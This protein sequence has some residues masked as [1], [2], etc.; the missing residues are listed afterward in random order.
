V[1]EPRLS[2]ATK[3]LLHAARS[4]APS[5]AAR[6]KIWLGASAAAG[7]A[8]AA[9]AAGAAG[10]GAAGAGA[11]G[12]GIVGAAGAAKMLALG[13][14]LGGTVTVGLAVAFLRIG[15]SPSH[16]PTAASVGP[17]AALNS[18]AH[19]AAALPPVQTAPPLSQPAPVAEPID[20]PPVA[21]SVASPVAHATSAPTTRVATAPARMPSP[22][23]GGGARSAPLAADDALAREAALVA[24]ARGA[25]VRG[26]A[27]SALRAV[28]AA[29]V[30]PSHQLGPEELAV[31]AQALRALGRDEDAKEA[32]SALRRQFPESVFAR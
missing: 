11:G 17:V 32:D 16:V 14:L 7:T 25:L 6:A 2:A 23:G 15:P 27:E 20:A 18:P 22:A 9:G 30:L 19:A 3:A 4:D 10:S 31:E 1:S 29:R 24:E 12:A 28:R 13:T 21:P 5:A 8:G 26:D